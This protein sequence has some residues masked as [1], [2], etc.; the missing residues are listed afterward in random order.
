MLQFILEESHSGSE[1]FRG[2]VSP[3][4]PSTAIFRV[5]SEIGDKVV[6]YPEKCD[7]DYPNNQK[8]PE[9]MR[10]AK[11]DYHRKYGPLTSKQFVERIKYLIGSYI[12]GSKIPFSMRFIKKMWVIKQMYEA[13][14]NSFE[15]ALMRK[16]LLINIYER[17]IAIKREIKNTTKNE[18]MEKYAALA[19]KTLDRVLEKTTIFISENRLFLWLSTEA[20]YYFVDVATPQMVSTF[21]YLQRNYWLDYELVSD[22][23]EKHASFWEGL[24]EKFLISNFCRKEV[25]L[26]E[27]ICR[28]IA[29]FIPQ[30]IEGSCFIEYFRKHY[31]IKSGRF[32]T[33]SIPFKVSFNLLQGHAEYRNYI[34]VILKN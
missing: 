23:S 24:W 33:F 28:K 26:G 6:Y 17:G 18:K 19:E 25:H 1:F 5:E 10:E 27:D 9:N 32:R 22:I 4:V 21:T 30:K 14:D 29:E 3:L 8:E 20:K 2:G 12:L 11:R 13:V 34:S 16:K 15:I 31:D 7:K